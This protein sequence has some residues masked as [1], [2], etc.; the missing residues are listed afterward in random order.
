MTTIDSQH[1]RQWMRRWDAQQ[2]HYIADREERFDVVGDVVEQVT[3][4]QEAPVIVDLGC[5]PGSMSGR[6]ANRLPG[7][8]LI[9][10]DADPLLLALGRV[11]YTDRVRFVDADLAD[12]TWPELAGLP[13]RVDAAVSSTAL[14]WLEPAQ[15]AELYAQLASY[16]RP[17]GVFVNAD[18]LRLGGAAVEALAMRVRDGRAERVGVT[19]NEEWGEWWEAVLA[20]DELAPLV[21]QRSQR[22]I[23]HG[24]SE[25]EFAAQDHAELLRKAGFGEVGAVWQSGDDHV[26]VA[27]R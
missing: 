3:R 20:D 27:V 11:H 6:L 22:A 18:H 10:V 9:G 23:Q 26:L 15:L 2:E 16:L 14:H 4:G 8:E 7:A 19:G 17:G 24:G 5:G 13:E 1:A 12:P 21:R 25:N